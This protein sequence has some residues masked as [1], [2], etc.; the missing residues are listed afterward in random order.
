MKRVSEM[1]PERV[2]FTQLAEEGAEMCHAALKMA[3]L[4]DPE[5][6]ESMGD[7]DESK[8]I[9]NF[10]EEIGDVLCCVEVALSAK[11]LADVVMPEE[12]IMAIRDQKYRRWLERL[13]NQA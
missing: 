2:A 11:I 1:I 13:T 9:E 7:V 12:L 5:Q 4:S 8:I 6:R 3:R 10:L